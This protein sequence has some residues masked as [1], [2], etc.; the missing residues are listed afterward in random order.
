MKKFDFHKIFSW[1]A[2]VTLLVFVG[3]I[4][5]FVIDFLHLWE[6]DVAV[7][8]IFFGLVLLTFAIDSVMKENP[9]RVK[10]Y[11]LEWLMVCGFFL[12]LALTIWVW[13]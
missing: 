6:R 8:V 3:W 13:Y 11:F 10:K 1:M 9:E 4:G 5:L 2:W 12:F 7:L